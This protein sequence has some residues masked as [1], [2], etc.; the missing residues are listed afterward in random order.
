MFLMV[1]TN[2]SD[3]TNQRMK[4]IG[5]IQTSSHPHFKNTDRNFSDR[6][7]K[8]GG[9]GKNFKISNW[10]E[11]GYLLS[12]LREDRIIFRQKLCKLKFRNG[13]ASNANAFA[14]VSQ[15]RRRV[16]THFVT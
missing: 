15:M 6:K 16:K 14:R 9:Q 5:S 3:H 11:R 2:W 8:K 10:P 13:F 7:V 4:D 12:P 1:K